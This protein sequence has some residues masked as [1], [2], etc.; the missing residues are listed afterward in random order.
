MYLQMFFFFH[1]LALESS[2][3]LLHFLKSTSKMSFVLSYLFKLLIHSKDISGKGIIN[4]SKKIVV[5]IIDEEIVTNDMLSDL[6]LTILK[7][8]EV[9]HNH[10]SHLSITLLKK[11]FTTKGSHK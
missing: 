2:P 7:F 8:D 9:V 3:F 1:I 4:K 11:I 6:D 10:S 5:F